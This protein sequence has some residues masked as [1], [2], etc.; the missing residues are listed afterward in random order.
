M[1]AYPSETREVHAG[2]SYENLQQFVFGSRQIET[3]RDVFGE[4]RDY[5]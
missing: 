3:A 1:F 5:E 4:R 2:I